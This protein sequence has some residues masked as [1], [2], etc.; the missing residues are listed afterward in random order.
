MIRIENKN[1]NV[2]YPG[3]SSWGSPSE[4]KNLLGQGENSLLCGIFHLKAIQAHI[5]LFRLKIYLYSVVN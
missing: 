3:V 5:F 2:D 4:A 1:L